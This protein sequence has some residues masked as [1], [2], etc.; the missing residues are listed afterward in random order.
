MWLSLN[1]LSQK[2]V[3]WDKERPL[4]QVLPLRTQWLAEW[5]DCVKMVSVLHNAFTVNKAWHIWTSQGESG[6]TCKKPPPPATFSETPIW[7]I[8]RFFVQHSSSGPNNWTVDDNEA[9]VEASWTTQHLIAGSLPHILQ[10]VVRYYVRNNP[11]TAQCRTIQHKQLIFSPSVYQYESFHLLVWNIRRLVWSY[12]VLCSIQ[13][14][15]FL[16]VFIY[17]HFD[18]HLISDFTLFTSFFNRASRPPSKISSLRGDNFP[19]E[20]MRWVGAR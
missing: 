9:V 17:A 15:L 4:M 7:N 20:A 6:A 12:L 18:S 19:R 3:R 16:I 2:M 1:P 11:R 14:C 8:L 10:N 13:Q 5:F